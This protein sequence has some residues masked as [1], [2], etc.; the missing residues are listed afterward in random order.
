MTD[1]EKELRLKMAET[2]PRVY[3]KDAEEGKEYLTVGMMYKIKIVKI[4]GSDMGCTS[5][6]I[7]SETNL[8]NKRLN[9]AGGT[10]LI[11]YDKN[12][13]IPPEASPQVTTPTEE[14][15]ETTSS[16]KA[17]EKTA[18]LAPA[19]TEEKKETSAS[20]ETE[21]TIKPKKVNMSNIINPLLLE[22]K[23]AEDIANAVI[24]EVT[25]EGAEAPDKAALIRQIRGPRR[26]NLIKKLEKDNKE[27]P[28]HLKENKAVENK[29]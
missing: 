13:H 28:A 10:E 24:T 26:Y 18:T 9:I 12:L 20:A 17:E 27:V 8:D 5:V 14:K 15:T 23:P 1:K 25:K 19:S 22:G 3:A 11:S 7:E 21:K 6:T 2:H 16:V 4:N 29:T